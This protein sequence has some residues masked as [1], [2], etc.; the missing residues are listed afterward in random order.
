N[1]ALSDKEL[2]VTNLSVLRDKPYPIDWLESEI[3]VD[4]SVAPEIMRI[5]MDGDQPED[6]SLIMKAVTKSYM[7]DVVNGERDD[8]LRRRDDLKKI[9]TNFDNGLQA[10]RTELKTLAKRLGS[11]DSQSMPLIHVF[12]LE[13]LSTAKKNLMQCRSDQQRIKA[14]L[15]ARKL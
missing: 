7:R 6:L 9:H 5:S 11:G 12:S 14:E 15:E 2:G 8:R 1:A 10:K 3:K 4:N 13:Q